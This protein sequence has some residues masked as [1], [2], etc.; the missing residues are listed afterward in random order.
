MATSVR[1]SAPGRLYPSNE[2]ADVRD[3][4]RLRDAQPQT[5]IAKLAR[6]VSTMSPLGIAGPF[7]QMGASC[8]TPTPES[9]RKA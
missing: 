3:G 8:R 9:V 1:M 2:F 5:Q 4:S 6:L 7:V